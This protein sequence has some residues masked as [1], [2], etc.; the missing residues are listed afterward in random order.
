L[1][2]SFEDIILIPLPCWLFLLFLVGFFAMAHVHKTRRADFQAPVTAK[3]AESGKPPTSHSSTPVEPTARPRLRLRWTTYLYFLFTAGVLILSIDEIARLAILGWGIGLLPFLPIVTII[4][5]SLYLMRYRLGAIYHGS[6][7]DR[8]ITA[9]ILVFWVMMMVV[10]AVKLHTLAK[11][12]RPFPRND[13][14]YPVDQ[15]ILDVAVLIGCMGLVFILTL[16][17]FVR[18]GMTIH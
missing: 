3:Q 2:T 6:G 13:S 14:K 15:Q 18:P 7:F 11:L 12:R 9:R 5:T 17:E 1:T 10:E 16:I 4:A 8:G